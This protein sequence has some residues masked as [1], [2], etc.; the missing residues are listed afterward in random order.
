M[1]RKERKHAMGD[2]KKAVDTLPSR[3]LILSALL[4]GGDA[5]SVL[6][7]SVTVEPDGHLVISTT[8]QVSEGLSNRI[9]MQVLDDAK[10]RVREVVGDVAEIYV[11]PELVGFQSSNQPLTDEIVIKAFD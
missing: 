2:S 1:G 7:L 6:R 9:L 3:E 11:E 10:R 4:E 5:E 8:I